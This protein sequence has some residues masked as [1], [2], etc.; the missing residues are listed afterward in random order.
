LAADLRVTIHSDHS[1]VSD[2]RISLTKTSPVAAGPLLLMDRP[3]GTNCVNGK[4][5]QTAFADNGTSLA[6]GCSANEPAINRRTAPLQ[7]L[8][9]FAPLEG[10]GTW[11]LTIE[12]TQVD[13]NSG[14]LL[15]WC[16]ST[17]PQLPPLQAAAFVN[18]MMFAN[19]FE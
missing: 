19:G 3:T 2:L 1:D 10:A 13:G 8:A 18:P 7:A 4:R 17:D 9:S 12:D 16:L 6:A 5:I 11:R 15:E 14:S